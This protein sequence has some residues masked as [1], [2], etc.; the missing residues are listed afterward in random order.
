MAGVVG[1][2]CEGQPGW[3]DG[4]QACSELGGAGEGSDGEWEGLSRGPL[5]MKLMEGEVMVAGL[6]LIKMHPDSQRRIDSTTQ[7]LVPQKL[8]RGCECGIKGLAAVLKA[9]GQGGEQGGRERGN[10]C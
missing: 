6:Q 1:P 2:L 8:Q 9:R 5:L 7:F 3:N 4:H 10:I